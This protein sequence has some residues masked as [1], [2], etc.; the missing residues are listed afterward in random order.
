MEY[1]SYYYIKFARY[2]KITKKLTQSGEPGLPI[3]SLH[4]KAWLVILLSNFTASED[5]KFQK[6]VKTRR[7]V[8]MFR[9]IAFICK[10]DIYIPIITE[11]TSFFFSET[12]LV[13]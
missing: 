12:V 3:L 4:L 11:K 7:Y 13:N 6:N 10:L 1:E 2:P 9:F 8:A 5:R